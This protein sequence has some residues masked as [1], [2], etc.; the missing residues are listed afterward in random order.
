MPSS[1]PVTLTASVRSKSS[2]STLPSR[3]R[4]VV[5]ALFD[6]CVEAPVPLVHLSCDGGPV[7]RVRD[8]EPAVRNAVAQLGRFVPVGRDDGGALAGERDSL[9][10]ALDHPPPP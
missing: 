10:R 5:P 9:G 1:G 7:V 2:R 6:E 4:W 3:A 8:V